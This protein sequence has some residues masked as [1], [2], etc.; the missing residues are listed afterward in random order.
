MPGRTSLSS[1]SVSGA[2]RNVP[3]AIS[4]KQ[5]QEQI[6]FSWKEDEQLYGYVLNRYK[7]SASG[8]GFVTPPYTAY[9]DLIWGAPPI[10]DLAKYKDL[11][12]R[13]PY[14]AAC[15]RVKSNMAISNGFELESGEENVRKWLKE[16]CDSHNLLQTLRIVVWD[17]LVEGNA[18]SEICGLNDNVDP[19][20]WW[21]KMLDPVHM[22][23]RRD[24][25]ANVFGYVQLLTFPPVAFTA[26]EVVHFK[27]EPK[28]NWYEYNYGTSE[29]RPLLLTQAYIDSMERD[30]AIIISV[31]LKP[32]F[33][34]KGG[35]AERPF[36]DPQ[37]TALMNAFQGRRPA[38]DIFVRGDVTVNQVESLTR[39]INFTPWMDY[40]ERQRKA[41]LG[42]PEI[43][44]GEPGGTNRAT[45]EV[46]MQ[47]YVTRLR[48]IQE[49]IADD[50]ETMLFSQLIEAKFGKGTEIPSIKWKPIW[51]PGLQEKAA[52]YSNL[53]QLGAASIGEVRV[54]VGLPE[55][56]PVDKQ[57]LTPD[58]SAEITKSIE[59][60]S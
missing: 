48:I 16:W 25:Y 42:V 27:N 47:E 19:E 38:T 26:Q 30:M 24:Q 31:Y 53:L 29:I 57:T 20:L 7:L 9:W 6:P 17:M 23:V 58:Q 5:I 44:L 37:L 11:A 8:V 45:A 3:S 35:T 52:V 39:T 22:R 13:I 1:I 32:M 33:V 43:F 55:Q 54:A 14:I 4:E 12:T 2:D 28:S 59:P 18:Y 41:I 15:M 49:I 34:V 40:L 56:I 51:E 21:L 50:L 46:V 60:E 36:S 10:E